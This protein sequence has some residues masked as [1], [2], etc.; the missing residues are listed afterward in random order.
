MALQGPSPPKPFHDSKQTTHG[1]QHRFDEAERGHSRR[2]RHSPRQTLSLRRLK[3]PCTTNRNRATRTRSAHGPP[4]PPPPPAV[5]APRHAKSSCTC[6]HPQHSTH[7]HNVAGQDHGSQPATTTRT[8][9]PSSKSFQKTRGSLSRT[10]RARSSLLEGTR[11]PQRVQPPPP[12]PTAPTRDLQPEHSWLSSPSRGLSD[13]PP[14]GAQAVPNARPFAYGAHFPLCEELQPPLARRHGKHSKTPAAGAH[15]RHH[16][17]RPD[18]AARAGEKLSP[19]SPSFFLKP[20]LLPFFPIL[21]TFKHTS[22]GSPSHKHIQ[23]SSAYTQSHP[24]ARQR[25]P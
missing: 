23:S 25:H 15:A 14:L 12:P 21:T 6:Q 17:Q 4:P 11:K 10:S 5:T 19:F 18:A 8:H 7:Q 22:G 1:T 16:S 13:T 20:F 3:T 24:L 9:F 2:F